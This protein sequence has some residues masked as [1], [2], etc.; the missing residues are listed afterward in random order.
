MAIGNLVLPSNIAPG[1]PMTWE[2]GQDLFE[3]L[4]SADNASGLSAH[5][6][7]ISDATTNQAL[8]TI[9]APQVAALGASNVVHFNGWGIYSTPSSGAATL[10]FVVYSGGSAGTALATITAFT[11]TAS[12]TNTPF[13]LEAWVDVYS[14]T[15]MQ[16]VIK[17]HVGTSDSTS[18]CTPYVSCGTTAGGTTVTTGS[19]LTLNA[20]MGTAVSGSSFEAL[21]GSWNQVA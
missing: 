8:V 21:G 4:T 14:A 12:M 1:S 3:Q 17:A 7:A 19:T 20:V 13:L 11:P 16:A 2:M 15:A 6:T 10:S 18:A 9:G 5:G